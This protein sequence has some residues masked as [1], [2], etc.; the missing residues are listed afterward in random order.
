MW[1]SASVVFEYVRS[2][3]GYNNKMTG[4]AGCRGASTALPSMCRYAKRQQASSLTSVS[5]FLL[6][7]GRDRVGDQSARSS[8][9]IS[10][11]VH[12]LQLETD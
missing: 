10:R 12:E 1:K 3:E 9:M 5:L 7:Q 2:K 11:Y 4:V 8:G 6:D